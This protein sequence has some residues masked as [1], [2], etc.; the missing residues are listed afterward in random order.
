M[1]RC[2]IGMERGTSVQLAAYGLI[3]VCF[4]L[5]PEIAERDL[6]RFHDDFVA[7]RPSDDKIVQLG[8]ASLFNVSGSSTAT[9]SSG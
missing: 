6:A 4:T 9:W 3:F 7:Q 1:I 2:T 8:P 5:P